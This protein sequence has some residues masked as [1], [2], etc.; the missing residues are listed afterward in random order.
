MS[1]YILYFVFIT[2]ALIALTFLA[3]VILKMGQA[4]SSCPKT[5]AAAKAGSLVVVRG[6]V[7]VGI[8]AYFSCFCRPALH[9][10]TC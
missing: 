4:L 6:F 3:H 5:S 7:V 1:D 9:S 10:R 2:T 8:G